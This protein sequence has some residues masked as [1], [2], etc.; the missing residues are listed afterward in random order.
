M[1]NSHDINK[2]VREKLDS[3]KNNIKNRMTRYHI[4]NDEGKVY[5]RF[6]GWQDFNTKIVGHQF[7]KEEIPVVVDILQQHGHTSIEVKKDKTG[8][9]L[10]L[11]DAL[12]INKE[13]IWVYLLVAP[14]FLL[15]YYIVR[16][17]EYMN[18]IMEFLRSR[19]ARIE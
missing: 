18:S 10:H 11:V 14:A 6:R 16:D 1:V 3:M 5:S 7:Q 2:E 19:Q 17:A 12:T 15:T 8:T 9:L 4:L 13:T